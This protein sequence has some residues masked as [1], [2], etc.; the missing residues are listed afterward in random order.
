M[1]ALIDADII[2]YEFGNMRDL[3]TSETLAWPIVRKFVD[4][5]ISKILEETEAT[6]YMLFLTESR[7]NFRKDVATILPYKGNRPSDK[8]PHWENIREHLIEEYEAEVVKGFEADDALG[9]KQMALIKGD[10][11]LSHI[12]VETIICS[13]DKDL[14]MIP[15]WHYQWECGKQA[16]RKWFVDETDGLRFFYKQLITGDSTDN[17]LGL[18]GVG[19]KSTLVKALDNI[20]DELEMYRHVRSKYEDRFGSYYWQ[21]LLEN[22][23]LL[24]ILR[25]PVGD[26][27]GAAESQVYDRLI[28]LEKLCN[29]CS[30]EGMDDGKE[31]D[32][33]AASQ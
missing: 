13:R 8:P 32:Q 18:F 25:E 10:R 30:E 1:L 31:S 23:K 22:A 15:G 33:E 6:D 19:E 5:R 17:I 9:I 27:L 21:F 11:S 14:G 2:C 12:E 16:M 3:E 7:S 20:D 28:K 4:E 29:E 24:W 26:A